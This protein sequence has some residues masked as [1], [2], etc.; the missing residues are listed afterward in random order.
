MAIPLTSA[1]MATDLYVTVHCGALHM[2]SGMTIT[3]TH[4]ILD[5]DLHVAV[6]CILP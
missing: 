1:V 4:A 5:T 2:P 3:M 6:H